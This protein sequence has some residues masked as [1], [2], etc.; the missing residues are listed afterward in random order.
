M[1]K[2]YILMACVLFSI[3]SC[4]SQK[5][6]NTL[7]SEFD[8]VNRKY[9]KLNIKSKEIEAQRQ[10]LEQQ[11]AELD[12][13]ISKL[14]DLQSKMNSKYAE[15]TGGL[16]SQLQKEREELD[17]LQNEF[18][19][20]NKKLI[21]LQQTLDKKEEAV[22]MLRKRVADALLG[23]EGKGLTVTQKNGKVYISLEE[24]LLFKSGDWNIEKGGVQAI[25]EL[26]KI[27]A[28]NHD[29]NVMVEGHTDNVSYIGKGQIQDHWDLS[30]KRATTV[31]PT[32]LDKTG[33]NP[34][35]VI[36]AGRSEYMPIEIKNT[37]ENRQ[38]NRRTEII[39]T[40]KLDELFE[41]LEFN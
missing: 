2:I 35:Q 25:K 9:N 20:N 18:A 16:Q 5:K 3:M 39:L 7:Q 23:F 28:H 14:K 6:F 36:A 31:V 38:K 32:L 41:I 12:T 1:M 19:E 11:K 24:R 37:V 27:L 22:K 10:F 17:K 15:E 26:A 4:V 34:K 8:T 21:E 13:K 30:V 33:V 29:I 40:P